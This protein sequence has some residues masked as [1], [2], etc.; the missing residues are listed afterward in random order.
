MNYWF[1]PP[2]AE[3]DFEHPYSADFWPNDFKLRFAN[4]K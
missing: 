3:N 4:K 1:H 2:D